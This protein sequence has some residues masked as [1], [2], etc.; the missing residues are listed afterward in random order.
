MTRQND[1]IPV[2]RR[3]GGVPWWAWLVGLAALAL[4]LLLLTGALGN[5]NSSASPTPGAATPEVTVP[6]DVSPEA[7]APLGG[8][9][10]ASGSPLSSWTL[11]GGLTV[12]IAAPVAA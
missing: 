12:A 9:P 3:E 10:A 4:A 7:S 2:R 11:P 5:N 1:E 8:S 6:V